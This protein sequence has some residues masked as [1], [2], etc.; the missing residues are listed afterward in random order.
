MV[1]QPLRNASATSWIS[2]SVMSGGEKLIV[3]CE[4]FP[5]SIARFFL[6]HFN[7]KSIA[8]AHLQTL[9]AARMHAFSKLAR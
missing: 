9:R 2:A 3:R 7:R 6:D 5:K 4:P 8:D 1:I